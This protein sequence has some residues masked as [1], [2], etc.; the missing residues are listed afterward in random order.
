M[1]TYEG[2]YFSRQCT[3][4][5]PLLF[6]IYINSLPSQ[7]NNGLV[8]QYADDTTI[9]CTAPT[10]AAVQSIMCAQL[11]VIQQWISQSKMKVNIKKSSVMPQIALRSLHILLFQLI[12]SCCKW[13]RNRSIWGLSLTVVCRGLTMLLMCTSTRDSSSVFISCCW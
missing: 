8:L 6:L 2:W 4:L 13:L 12:M 1:E 7:L 3:A 11:S 9:V 5:D 10:P